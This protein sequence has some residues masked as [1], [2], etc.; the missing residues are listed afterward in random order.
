MTLD[1]GRESKC[2][3]NEILKTMAEL[4]C[5]QSHIAM[6]L[7][8]LQIKERYS[9]LHS[10]DSELVE[11]YLEEYEIRK[12]Y[13]YQLK[14]KEAKLRVLEKSLNTLEIDTESIRKRI[15]IASM[16]EMV[17][18]MIEATSRERLE[19]EQLKTDFVNDLEAEKC[20]L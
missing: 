8:I 9:V 6:Y 15:A 5:D 1:A 7:E 19:I 3:Y 16:Q 20:V 13:S 17:A 11:D 12:K 14:K 10:S 2:D 4:T 18:R